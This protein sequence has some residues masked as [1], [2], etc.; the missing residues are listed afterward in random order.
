MENDRELLNFNGILGETGGPSLPPISP[1]ELVRTIL[2]QADPPNLADLRARHRQDAQSEA[3][4]ARLQQLL[5]ETERKLREA[6]IQP[7]DAATALALT[8]S[9]RQLE[10]E[11]RQRQHLGVREGIDAA[12]LHQAGWGVIFAEDAD[13]LVLA[14]LE[15]LLALRREQAGARFHIYSGARGYRGGGRDTKSK[16][17][18]RN[19]ATVAGPASP[20]AVPY[21]LLIV[22]GPD[23]I[24]FE[25]QYQLDVQYAVGRLCFDTV[26]EYASYAR[27]VV[28][29]EQQPPARPQRLTFFGVRNPDDRAT[30]V[31]SRQLVTPLFESMRQ[32]NPGWE[33]TRVAPADADKDRLRQLLG[34][35]APALLFTASHGMVFKA[36]NRDQQGHQGA[37]LCQDWPGPSR[38]G[39]I[40]RQSYFSGEDIDDSA[41]IHGM[42]LFLFACYSVGTSELDSFARTAAPVQLAAAPFVSALPRRLLSHPAGGA[43]AVIGHVDRAWSYSFAWSETAQRVHTAAIE[44]TLQR[45]MQGQRIGYAMEYLNQRYAELATVLSDELGAVRNLRQPDERALAEIWI[46]THDARG[47]CVLGDPAVRLAPVNVQPTPEVGPCAS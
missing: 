36:G 22:G 39:P 29:A 25:F 13:P 30:E 20:D 9:L 17:L 3:A 44:S 19:G 6:P 41:C 8:Q 42:M 45:L 21:Y 7:S 27:S 2:R 31:S 46:A 15:P 12:D 23:K 40:P 28:A 26:Q 10:Q 4:M 38:M 16:F 43:L 34:S 5:D 37:L 33:V 18:V 32:D 14:A 47:Y 11:L 1:A 35:E 24:P